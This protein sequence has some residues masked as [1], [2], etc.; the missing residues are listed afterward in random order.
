[1]ARRREKEP[2]DSP[3]LRFGR[4]IQRVMDARDY[5]Q[6]QFAKFITRIGMPYGDYRLTPGTLQSYLNGRK[7]HLPIGFLLCLYDSGLFTWENG[8]LVSV[9][10]LGLVSLGILDPPGLSY[11]THY[12]EGLA[13]AKEIVG[14]RPALKVANSLNIPPAELSKVLAG[15][16]PSEKIMAKLIAAYDTFEEQERLKQAFGY[17]DSA[18]PSPEEKS[19]GWLSDNSATLGENQGNTIVATMTRKKSK[20]AAELL[21]Q[22]VGRRVAWASR[23]S[24]ISEERIE[25]L[26][27]GYEPNRGEGYELGLLFDDASQARAYFIAFDQAQS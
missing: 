22:R 20:I 1:M 4:W 26:L 19:A 8:E 9:Q 24:G 17:G 7:E 21:R 15:D 23:Q 6:E 13:L 11:D 16:R 27:E 18:N 2:V 5:T 25:E 3:A 10:E 14:D 12:P